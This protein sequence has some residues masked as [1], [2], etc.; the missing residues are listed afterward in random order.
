MAKWMIHTYRPHMKIMDVFKHPLTR[1]LYEKRFDY[2]A[3]QNHNATRGHANKI[4]SYAC[5]ELDASERKQLVLVEADGLGNITTESPVVAFLVA[6]ELKTMGVINK[7]DMNRTPV[8]FELNPLSAPLPSEEE[9]K[10]LLAE[11]TEQ[12]VS[13]SKKLKVES[14]AKK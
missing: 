12:F 14:K 5:L 13:L 6:E 1:D 4:N 10:K 2:D 9:I 11:Q 7:P 8:Q 3:I